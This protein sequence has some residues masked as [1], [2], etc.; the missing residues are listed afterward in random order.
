VCVCVCARARERGVVRG[1]GQTNAP[2]DSLEVVLREAL[3]HRLEADQALQRFG[4]RAREDGVPE[5][6]VLP[7][8]RRL[9]RHVER[10]DF[11]AQNVCREV[12][13]QAKREMKR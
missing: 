9:A 8:L 11:V 6:H 4:E 2:K 7:Q 5:G 13:A 3:N 10:V 1:Y 12:P